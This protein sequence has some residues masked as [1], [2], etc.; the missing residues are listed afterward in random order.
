MNDGLGRGT[1]RTQGEDE[2]PKGGELE[3]AD[4]GVRVAV[5][6]CGCGGTDTGVGLGSWAK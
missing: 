5:L 2:D 4:G 6:C 1:H 3:W